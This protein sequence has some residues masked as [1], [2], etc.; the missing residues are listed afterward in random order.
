MYSLKR[1]EVISLIN[2]IKNELYKIFHKKGIYIVLLITL[3]FTLLTNI[4]YNSNF[5][6]EF[7]MEADIE[8]EIY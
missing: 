1:L 6:E 8:I 2:L 7:D 5:L 4:I 3:L